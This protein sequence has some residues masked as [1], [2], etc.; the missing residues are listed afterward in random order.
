MITSIVDWNCLYIDRQDAQ[1]TLKG[2]SMVRSRY[3]NCLSLLSAVLGVIWRDREGP[4]Q[5]WRH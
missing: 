4:L 5:L 3:T 2:R 1:Y